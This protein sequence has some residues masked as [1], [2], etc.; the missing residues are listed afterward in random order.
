MFLRQGEDIYPSYTH[1]HYT[2]AHSYARF[3]GDP[4]SQTCCH[5]SEASAAA[6][7]LREMKRE[8]GS[9]LACVCVCVIWVCSDSSIC[10]PVGT[11]WAYFPSLSAAV[12]VTACLCVVRWHQG[13]CALVCGSALGV[14]VWVCCCFCHCLRSSVCVCERVNGLRQMM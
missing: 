10:T 3:H 6:G 7:W 1:S 5:A 4:S 8:M 13:F 11:Q 14:F 9:E 12:C 2:N